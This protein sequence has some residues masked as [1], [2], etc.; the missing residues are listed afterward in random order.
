[1]SAC[2]LDVVALLLPAR[3]CHVVRARLALVRY[4]EA[5]AMLL[6]DDAD[7]LACAAL[8]VASIALS[9]AAALLLG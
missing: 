2:L 9:L 5:V 8:H 6:E 3:L 1:M 4:A 7:P